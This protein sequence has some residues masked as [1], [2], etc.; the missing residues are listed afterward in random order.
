[1]SLFINQEQQSGPYRLGRHVLHDEASKDFEAR[2]LIG[3]RPRPLHTVQH[4]VEAPIW[5][6]GDIGQCTAEAAL[7][8]LMFDQIRK[9]EWR[10]NGTGK[11]SDTLSLYREETRLDD[12]QIAGSWEPEDT[13]STGV[14]SMKALHKQGLIAS[15]HWAFSLTTVLQLLLDQPVSTGT[16]WYES[17]FYPDVEGVLTVDDSK[18]ASGGHQYLLIGLDVE[19]EQVIG[20]NSWGPTWGV[21]GLFRMSFTDYA[22]LLADN[23]DAVVPVV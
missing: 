20:R 12:S 19:K 11:D 18:S 14:W 8:S 9:P 4:K 17:M 2:K 7:G 23:G 13:G 3:R 10:F 16:S 21:E 1:M 15:Y 6:Q 5:D 22:K